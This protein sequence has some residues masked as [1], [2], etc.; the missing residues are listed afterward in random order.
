MAA[1]SNEVNRTLEQV[2]SSMLKLRES[3]RGIQIRTAGFKRLH[4]DFARQVAAVSVHV[5]DSVPA[6]LPK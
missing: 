1:Y 3:M 4:D 2:G 5:A 6:M